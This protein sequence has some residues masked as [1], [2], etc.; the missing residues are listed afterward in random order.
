M[1]EV[2]ELR[3]AL[4]C[5]KLLLLDTMIFSY[6]LSNHPRYASLAAV[7]LEMVETGKVMGV[8]TTVTLA[9][10]LTVPAQGGNRR[11]MQ[12]YELYLAHFPNLQIVSLDVA[13]ARETA[14]V[15]AETSLRVPDAVQIAAARLSGADGIV[16]ND[17]RWTRRV[18]Q[19]TLILLD[20]YAD[21]A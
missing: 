4:S 6:H 9:E 19:P 16:T 1:G 3:R 11:A 12:E 7:V 2:K 14:V 17:R 18:T 20:D 8:T 5:Y 10:L 15:R 21:A 13:L